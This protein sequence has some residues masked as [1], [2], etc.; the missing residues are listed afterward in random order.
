VLRERPL[1]TPLECWVQIVDTARCDQDRV[2]RLIR[3]PSGWDSDSKLGAN[4]LLRNDHPKEAAPAEMMT[5]DFRGRVGC[6]FAGLSHESPPLCGSGNFSV[7]PCVIS[8]ISQEHPER[9][10]SPG[11]TSG[12]SGKK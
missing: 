7:L 4:P 6:V 8:V 5:I 11:S 9:R 1:E 10:M 2:D 3:V 12:F